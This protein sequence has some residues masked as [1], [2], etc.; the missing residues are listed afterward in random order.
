M[1]DKRKPKKEGLDSPP[2]S[3]E[4]PVYLDGKKIGDILVV[5]KSDSF[6]YFPNGS[7]TGGRVFHT[8]G[9]CFQSLKGEDEEQQDNPA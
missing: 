1:S 8:F 2:V 3:H 7:K 4:R 6:Q 9:D 5:P